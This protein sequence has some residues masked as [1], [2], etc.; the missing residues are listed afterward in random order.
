MEASWKLAPVLK[1]GHLPSNWKLVSYSDQWFDLNPYAMYAL[2]SILLTLALLT[3][4]N[5]VHYKCLRLWL[6]R[7]NPLTTIK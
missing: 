5:T 3:K 1:H 6:L 2:Y 4:L 7:S